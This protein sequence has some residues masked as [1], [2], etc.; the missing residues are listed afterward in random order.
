MANAKPAPTRGVAVELDRTRYL[1]YTLGVLKRLQEH[2]ADNSLGQILLL[3]LKSDDP[4]LT[5]EQ[6]EEMIDLENLHTLFDPVKRAT[7]GLI[8][9]S[10]VFKTMG[11][12]DPQSPLPAAGQDSAS[13]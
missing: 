13:A 1:R 10:V 9:L 6:V 3:G 4:A 7:G 12:Q 5:V 2:G 11:S 8:D